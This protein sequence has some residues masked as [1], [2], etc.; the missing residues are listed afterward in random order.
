MSVPLADASVA[1]DVTMMDAGAQGAG[2]GGK[3]GAAERR[4]WTAEEDA[5]IAALVLQYGTRSWSTIASHLPTRSGKQCRERWHNHLDPVINKGEWSEEEDARLIA[6]H[7]SL[8][9]RYARH[10]SQ[11]RAP[12]AQSRRPRPGPDADRLG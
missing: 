8:G 10:P 5:Q 3:E 12:P 1:S 2:D 4:V 11:A 7:R 6:A 9:N